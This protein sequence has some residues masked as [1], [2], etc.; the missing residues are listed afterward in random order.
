MTSYTATFSNG[1]VRRTK[2]ALTYSHAW[3]V[4]GKLK[5]GRPF[6]LF[7]FSTKSEAECRKQMS[8]DT[9]YLPKKDGATID[10][11]EVVAVEAAAVGVPA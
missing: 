6:S 5:S 10:F 4:T 8:R 3:L 7:G 11:S 2:R 9:A 1:E